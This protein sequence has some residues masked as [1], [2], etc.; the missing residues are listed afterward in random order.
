MCHHAKLQQ[1]RP[2][3]F[4]DITLFRFSR[5]PSSAILDIQILNIWY[6]SGWDG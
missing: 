1:N 4:A 3:G 6:W 5:W 2:N